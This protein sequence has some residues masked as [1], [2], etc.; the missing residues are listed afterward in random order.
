MRDWLKCNG[1]SYKKPAVVPGKANAEQQ[2]KWMKERIIYNTY[3]E[4]VEDFRL[5]VFGFFDGISRL[6][7]E[8]VLGQNLRS[9]VR[10]KSSPINSSKRALA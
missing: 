8:S 3:Y 4:Y 10:D 6:S 7:A 1:F 2:Q 9:R 5:A